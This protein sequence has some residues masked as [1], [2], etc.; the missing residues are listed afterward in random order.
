MKSYIFVM[1]SKAE[2][3]YIYQV[4]GLDDNSLKAQNEFIELSQKMDE[5]KGSTILAYDK[6]DDIGLYKKVVTVKLEQA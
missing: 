6:L 4:D 5:F 1:K 2:D 3:I